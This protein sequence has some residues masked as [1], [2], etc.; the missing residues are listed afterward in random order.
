V[1]SE[2]IE[3]CKSKIPVLT[4]LERQYPEHSSSMPDN[5]LSRH[6]AFLLA[7]LTE[8]QDK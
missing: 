1:I 6:V 7:T 3:K 5:L 4:A 8:A 2:L